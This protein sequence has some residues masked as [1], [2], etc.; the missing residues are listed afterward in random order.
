[1]KLE[2]SLEQI[3]SIAQVI[4]DTCHESKIFCLEGDLGAGK[5]TLVESICNYLGSKDRFNSPTFSIINEY[6]LE[7]SSI[8]HADLYRLKSED[9]LI[10]IGLE[11]Y[12]YSGNY[13]FIEWYQI[14]KDY[15]PLPYYIVKINTIEDMRRSVDIEL[16]E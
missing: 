2:Y 9:E 11:D 8:I 13:C 15:L 3:E 4:I 14:A 12:V 6:E 7:G 16:I 5:T 10:G 1:M